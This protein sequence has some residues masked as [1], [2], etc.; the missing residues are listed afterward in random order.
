MVDIINKF[1]ILNI[2]IADDDL[3]L[4]D[5]MK[6]YLSKL[7]GIRSIVVVNDGASVVQ[8]IHNQKFDL[9]L[10]D[11]KMPKK[12]GYEILNEFKANPFNSITSVVAM[13]GTMNREIFDINKSNGV[14]SFL[15]KPFDEELFREKISAVIPVKEKTIPV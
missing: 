13:S 5:I 12:N 11:M 14:K 15:I 3:E 9:I 6:F 4:C 8:K 1:G 2:L 7:D 10:L